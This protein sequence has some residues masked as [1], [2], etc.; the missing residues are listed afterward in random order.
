[1]AKEKLPV[2]TPR[3]RLERSVELA[4]HAK[5]RTIQRFGE[6][7]TFEELDGLVKQIHSNEA[8]FLG[9]SPRG[10]SIFAV[11]FK[12]R[13][14]PVFYNKNKKCIASVLPEQALTEYREKKQQKIEAHA[15]EQAKRAE[16]NKARERRKKERKSKRKMLESYR[17]KL[18]TDFMDEIRY[19]RARVLQEYP[20]IMS[21]EAKLVAM[22]EDG[23]VPKVGRYEIGFEA[24]L[25]DFDGT[26]LGAICASQG[27][28]IFDLMSEEDLMKSLEEFKSLAQAMPSEE[29][30][31]QWA[32]QFNW[33][34]SS[35]APE[36]LTPET[37]A[38]K[39]K[40]QLKG[41][42]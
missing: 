19:N 34:S 39:V 4:V 20:R 33:S 27:K 26:K 37:Q 1:M 18:Q 9:M 35:L 29:L 32:S 15:V 5:K 28:L 22:I 31:T 36:I 7:I 2:W 10:T 21:Y 16:A 11:K 23:L 6:V 30:A 3:K 38:P 17:A 13:E 25:F 41:W 40:P 12:G 42:G 8:E 24:R 14:L